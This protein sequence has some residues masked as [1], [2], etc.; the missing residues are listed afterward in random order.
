MWARTNIAGAQ[1][2]DGLRGAG[3][4]SGSVLRLMLHEIVKLQERHAKR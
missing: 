2:G 4:G 1:A 3:L